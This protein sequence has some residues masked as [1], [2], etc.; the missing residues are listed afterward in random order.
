MDNLV[1]VW[2]GLIVLFLMI[3][4]ATMG[5]TTIWFA[6]GSIFSMLAALFGWSL[7]VQIGL[8]IIVSFI[9]FFFTRP[10]ALKYLKVGHVKTN[11]NAI[12]G[13]TGVV[14]LD[15]TENER[16]Q[17]KVNGQIWTAVSK[18]Q[19]PLKKGTEIEVVAVE[20]VKLIVKKI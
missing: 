1:Y 11:V 5:L 8:G 6:I 19:T 18:D 14:H 9:L 3:E 7:Q 13:K 2:V 12:I 10:V 4:G 16:G 17:V 20:G 15:T